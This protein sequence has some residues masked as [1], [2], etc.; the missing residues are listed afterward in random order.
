LC[1][2]WCVAE[3]DEVLEHHEPDPALGQQVCNGDDLPDLNHPLHTELDSLPGAHEGMPELALDEHG[4]AHGRESREQIHSGMD[5]D[6]HHAEAG[7]ISDIEEGARVVILL[8][9]GSGNKSGAYDILV[10]HGVY[11]KSHLLILDPTLL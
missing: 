10:V 11:I 3:V 4:G 1:I 8:P 9:P 2:R 6:L 5:D 7:P